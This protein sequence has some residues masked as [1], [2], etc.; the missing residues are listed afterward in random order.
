MHDAPKLVRQEQLTRL[1]LTGHSMRECAAQ[2]DV[3]LHTVRK[4]AREPAFLAALKELS[5]EVFRRVD[6]ELQSTKE[7]ML[8]KLEEASDAALDRMLELVGSKNEI[9]ALK[10]SQDLM[11]R[12]T[13]LSRTKRVE[14]TTRHDFLT[15][16][17]LVAAAQAAREVDE[18]ERTKGDLPANSGGSDS[19]S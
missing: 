8:A 9:V 4:W 14:G 5:S 10:S 6:E 11:D 7:N 2:M 1:L 13:A 17:H 19:G 18:Y 3:H 15:P 12:N 16:L